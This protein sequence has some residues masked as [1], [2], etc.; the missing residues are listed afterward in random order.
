MVV[1]PLVIGHV[2][3]LTYLRSRT[4][5]PV[6]HYSHYRHEHGM[7]QGNLCTVYLGIADF[8]PLQ[9]GATVC[10]LLHGELNSARSNLN[11]NYIQESALS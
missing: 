6:K 7:T 9:I 8:L 11:R 2:P 10:P 4:V 1:L 5:F 3:V